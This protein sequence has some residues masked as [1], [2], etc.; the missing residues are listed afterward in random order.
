MTTGLK[1]NV[2]PHTQFKHGH[3]CL[4]LL[5]TNGFLF[6]SAEVDVLMFSVFMPAVAIAP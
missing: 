4:E 6:S 2:L 3:F 1:A 5:V